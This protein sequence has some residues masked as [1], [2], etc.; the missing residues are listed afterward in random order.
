MKVAAL[1]M[2]AMDYLMV[3]ATVKVAAPA[4]S[5]SKKAIIL[6]NGSGWRQALDLPIH[7]KYT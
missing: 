5:P 1:A 7:E 6:M 3:P 2:A 4:S